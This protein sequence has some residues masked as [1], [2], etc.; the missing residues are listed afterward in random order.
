MSSTLRTTIFSSSLMCD[1]LNR[2]AQEQRDAFAGNGVFGYQ[3]DPLGQARTER[4]I[5]RHRGRHDNRD[6]AGALVRAE[7]LEHGK[8]V[9]GRHLQVE[10]D[11]IRLFFT[12]EFQAFLAAARLDEFI[13]R[14][15]ADNLPQHVAER[16]VVVDQQYALAAVALRG[17]AFPVRVAEQSRYFEG[18]DRA[19]SRNTFHLQVTAQQPR[20]RA[21]QRQAEAGALQL[22][23]QPRLDLRELLEDAL[24]IF[25][26]DTDAG[27]AHTEEDA[28][29]AH[30]RGDAHLALFGEFQRVGNQVAQDLGDLGLVGI[31]RRQI[32]RRLE[33]QIDRRR[34]QQR[35]ERAA[36]RAEQAGDGETNRP[37]VDL[38]RLDLGEIE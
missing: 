36:Q 13:L 14:L 27:V 21:R 7:L 18:E 9:N 2:V 25:L 31:Q 1:T 12:G 26:G 6:R 16:L 22:L 20:Q 28:I 19:L 23:L 37:H 35:L 5:D 32:L 15:V 17:D 8:A 11:D 4:G 3:P 24:V 10:D 34:R 29:F 38:A 33:Q 30:A